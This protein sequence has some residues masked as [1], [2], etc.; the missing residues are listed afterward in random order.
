MLVDA[1]FASAQYGGRPAEPEGVTYCAS[2]DDF[3]ARHPRLP[4]ATEQRLGVDA[5]VDLVIHVGT[6]DRVTEVHLE[7]HGLAETYRLTGRI[8]EAE[9]AATIIGSDVIDTLRPILR[10]LVATAQG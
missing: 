8:E 9:A 1:G 5:C 10:S 2:F 3:A 7:D 6:D 4:Q